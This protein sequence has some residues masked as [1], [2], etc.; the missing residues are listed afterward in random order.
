MQVVPVEWGSCSCCS[1]DSL[2]GNVEC[3]CSLFVREFGC[4]C[5]WG[6]EFAQ[7]TGGE[8]ER[9]WSRYGRTTQGFF[10]CSLSSLIFPTETPDGQETVFSKM[11]S[12]L[13]KDLQFVVKITITS[14]AH[15]KAPA[16]VAGDWQITDTKMDVTPSVQ[17]IHWWR[18]AAPSSLFP[19][20]T[21]YYL[22]F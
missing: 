3:E 15:G 13:E 20:R 17:S 8:S 11:K 9:H 21:L 18:W 10:A 19:W 2:W 1:W 6:G 16:W 4:W 7:I 22:D 12:A 14:Q 5:G